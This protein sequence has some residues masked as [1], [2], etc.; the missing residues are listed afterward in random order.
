M[1][2]SEFFSINLDLLLK[3]ITESFFAAFSM[4]KYI[5]IIKLHKMWDISLK[6]VHF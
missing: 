3:K 4:L 2:I 1:D 6:I 5:F